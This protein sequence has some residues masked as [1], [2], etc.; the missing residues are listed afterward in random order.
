MSA[1][2]NLDAGGP[3]IVAGMWIFLFDG[4]GKIE[5]SKLYFDVDVVIENELQGKEL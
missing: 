1:T 2:L 3:L 5:T 4:I